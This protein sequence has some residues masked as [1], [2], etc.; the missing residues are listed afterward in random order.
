M[1]SF[2]ALLVLTLALSGCGNTTGDRATSGAGIGA[3]AGAVLGAVTGLSVVEGVL[4]GAAAGGVTGAVTDRDTIDLGEPLWADA[5]YA[6]RTA[7]NGDRVTT[8][9][10]GLSRL[11]YDPGPA[12][13]EYGPRTKRAIKR[14]QADHGLL[15]DGLVTD[16]LASHIRGQV[17]QKN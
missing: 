14:Y 16:Q 17:A 13:G 5:N 4:I 9:Q 10:E 1:R 6:G 7:G 15:T 3:A 2:L 11:G 12:D 8:V